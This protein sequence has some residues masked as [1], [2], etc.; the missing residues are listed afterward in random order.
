MDINKLPKFRIT[1]KTGEVQTD[2]EMISFPGK[3]IPTGWD[4]EVEKIEVLLS[5][6]KWKDLVELIN[7][8]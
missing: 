2:Y 6:G 1:L 3:T 5:S 8:K 4:T 7:K